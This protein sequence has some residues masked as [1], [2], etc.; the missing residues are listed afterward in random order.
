MGEL[1]KR[2][3]HHP[4]DGEPQGVRDYLTRIQ[5]DATAALALLPDGPTPPVPPDG[6][7][8][9]PGDDLQAALDAGGVIQ[10]EDEATFEGCY[11]VKVPGTRLLGPR[12]AI[13]GTKYGAAINIPPGTKDVRVTLGSA[14]TGWDQR[15]VMVG[16]NDGAKQSHVDDAPEDI[17]LTIQVPQHRGKTAF[18]INGKDVRLI[19][20]SA[21]DVYAPSGQDSQGVGI[22]NAPGPVLVRGGTFEAAS[23]NIMVGG[24][25]TG[26]P[27][28]NP[29]GITVEDVQLVKREEW[30]TAGSPPVKNLFELKSGRNVVVRRVTGSGCWKSA[31]S[32]WAI[33]LTPRDG[34]QIE[35]YTFED[36]TLTDVGSGVSILA[37]DD[38]KWSGQT[39]NGVFRRFSVRTDKARGNGRFCSLQGELVGVRFEDCV[40]EGEENIIASSANVCWESETASHKGFRC[41]GV[42]LTGNQFAANPYGLHLAHDKCNGTS[43]TA[44][45]YGLQWQCAWPDGVISGNTFQGP[46]SG[47]LQK[48]LPPDNVYC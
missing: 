44:Y 45:A 25:S 7:I 31:Q 5:S 42:V 22:L 6:V 24:S 10:L 28:V 30:R 4:R 3:H 21:Y 46:K 32:G 34:K 43:V 47:E 33:M 27:D 20:C 35:N 29:T 39:T 13:V 38:S 14:R 15:C 18:Y 16:D 19:N 37:Y 48:N 40:Y 9:R 12:A 17:E 1:Y 23:E 41:T 8:V 2:H 11:I 26:I 36:I